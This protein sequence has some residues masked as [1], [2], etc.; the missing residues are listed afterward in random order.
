MLHYKFSK[1]SEFSESDLALTYN[2]LSKEQQEYINGLNPLKKDQSLAVR[3]LLSFLLK[4]MNLAVSIENLS[5]TNSGKPFL[6][7]SNI[8]ISLTHSKEYVGCAVSD[9]PV[10]IDIEQ[11]KDVKDGVIERV[12]S[13]DE[14]SYLAKSGKDEFF[15]LWTLKEAYIKAATE[16]LKMSEI[17]F[18]ENGK[19][20]DK[21]TLGQIDNYKWAIITL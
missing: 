2:L 7:D 10:G 5:A 9:K 15:T 11:I 6:S 3:C 13:K 16:T 19:I 18:V 4:E 1:F 17:S 12:C 20:T 8:F 14:I 21:Y